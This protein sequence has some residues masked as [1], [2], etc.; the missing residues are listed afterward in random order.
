MRRSDASR[1]TGGMPSEFRTPLIVGGAV[2]GVCAV[3]AAAA[4]LTPEPAPTTT[5]ETAEGE[6]ITV[7]WEDYPA[8]AY[9]APADALA[10]PS[11]TEIAEHW[12][13]ITRSIEERNPWDLD[14]APVLEDGWYPQTGNGYGGDSRQIT[15]NSEEQFTTGIPP[16]QDWPELIAIVDEVLAEHGIAPLVLDHEDPEQLGPDDWLLE[17]YGSTDPGEWSEWNGSAFA[18]G[19]W[20]SLSIWNDEL[21]PGDVEPET[22]EMRGPHGVSFSY[23]A[24]TV[25]DAER[26]VFEREIEPFLGLAPPEPTRSD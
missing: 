6:E 19:E 15:Y 7:S 21:F 10:A 14:F 4:V 9:T 11:E 12:A 5:Y 26:A 13:S 16:R 23:G 3:V 25:R 17:H 20:V 22:D 1:E 2:I 8:H 18:D 24:T